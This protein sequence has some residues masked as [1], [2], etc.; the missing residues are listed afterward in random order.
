MAIRVNS[1]KGQ[2]DVRLAP[3]MVVHELKYKLYKYHTML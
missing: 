2:V 1:D 3:L